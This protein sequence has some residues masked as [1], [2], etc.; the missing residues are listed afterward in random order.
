M[1]TKRITFR[2]EGKV[3]AAAR[4]RA[5][6]EGTTVNQR[7]QEWLEEYV[8]SRPDRRSDSPKDRS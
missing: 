8:R 3:I 2:A 7:F 6:R 5:R 4:E 1:G